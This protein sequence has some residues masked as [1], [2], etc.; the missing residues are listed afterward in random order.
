M[1]PLVA[2]G[3][4]GRGTGKASTKRVNSFWKI[5]ND[6]QLMSDYGVDNELVGFIMS[7]SG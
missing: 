2:D 3:V 6:A 4:R 1:V 7:F 5:R